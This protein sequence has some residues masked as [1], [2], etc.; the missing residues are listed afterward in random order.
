MA[1]NA[2]KYLPRPIRPGF[3]LAETASHILC[4]TCRTKALDTQA[5]AKGDLLVLDL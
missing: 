2:A 4:G 3:R 1:E 5:R